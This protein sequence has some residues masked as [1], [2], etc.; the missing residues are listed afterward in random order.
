MIKRYNKDILKKNI[1]I[2]LIVGGLVTVISI[3]GMILIENNEEFNKLYNQIIIMC[4]FFV[5]VSILT[6]IATDLRKI[7]IENNYRQMENYISENN[8]Y[9]AILYKMH[10]NNNLIN[11][12]LEKNIQLFTNYPVIYEDEYGIEIVKNNQ[13]LIIKFYEE[14]IMY[15]ILKI[16]KYE[17][18][19]NEGKWNKINN[20]EFNNEE[21]IIDFIVNIY[22]KIED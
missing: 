4:L 18:D 10:L 20:F 3:V 14:V 11:Q 7:D 1:A 8:S 5:G 21:Q 12:L 22:K 9:I 13:K 2:K 15:A 17:F 19:I 6:F 16:D